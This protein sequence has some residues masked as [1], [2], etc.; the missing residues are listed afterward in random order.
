MEW[1]KNLFG[2]KKV[3]EKRQ[4]EVEDEFSKGNIVL[5]S[6][7]MDYENYDEF[8]EKTSDLEDVQSNLETIESEEDGK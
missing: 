5:P 6:G 8:K 1:L 2:N 7:K 4:Q 3:L